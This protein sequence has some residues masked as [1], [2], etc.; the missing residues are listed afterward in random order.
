MN[1]INIIFYYISKEIFDD[2]DF[3]NHVDT[4]HSLNRCN[5]KIEIKRLFDF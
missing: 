1:E 2:S 4:I 5:N 3:E